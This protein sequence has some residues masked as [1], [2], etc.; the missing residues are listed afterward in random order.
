MLRLQ[1]LKNFLAQAKKCVYVAKESIGWTTRSDFYVVR[2]QSGD[3]TIGVIGRQGV[4][5]DLIQVFSS[6]DPLPV[7][8]PVRRWNCLSNSISLGAV[9]IFLGE[10]PPWARVK[11]QGQFVHQPLIEQRINLAEGFD[12]FFATVD[13]SQRLRF[14]HSVAAGDTIEFGHCPAEIEDFYNNFLVPSATSRHGSHASVPPLQVF[15]DLATEDCLLHIKDKAGVI[16]FTVFILRKKN[17][18]WRML[19][20]GLNVNSQMDKRRKA[21][22][23]AR[24]YVE[25]VKY[26]AA[27]GQKSLSLGLSPAAARNGIFGFKEDFNGQYSNDFLAY[28]RLQGRAETDVGIDK[29]TELQLLIRP[30]SDPSKIVPYQQA[31]TINLMDGPINNPRV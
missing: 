7:L 1:I 3:C 21:I 4:I 20:T 22:L 2:L 24:S 8:G 17:S 25:T 12:A 14:K 23:Q 18:E 10:I 13:R 15:L 19:R 30:A 27:S 6:N 31:Q 9:D 28:P 11:E 26:A 29:L 5:N 16:Q